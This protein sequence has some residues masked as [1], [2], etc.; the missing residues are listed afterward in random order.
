MP[1]SDACGCCGPDSR[2]RTIAGLLSTLLPR[3]QPVLEHEEVPL[4]A[5]RG[6]VLAVDLVATRPVPD[7]RRSA[8]DGYA[9]RPGDV[10]DGAGELMLPLRGRVAAGDS[11]LDLPD[12]PGLVRILTGAALPSA[13]DRVVMQEDCREQ[14]GMVHVRKIPAAGANVRLPGDDMEAGAVAVPAGTRLDPRHLAAAATL[15]LST[16][17]VCRRLRVAVL[18]TGSELV[19]PGQALRPGAIHNSNRF[20]IAGLLENMGFEVVDLPTVADDPE[21]VKAALRSAAGCDA[22]VTSGGVSVGD[23][24]HVRT[25]LVAVGGAIDHWRLAIKPGKPLA[26][27][28]LPGHDGRRTL[29]LGLPGNPNAVL[30]TLALVGLPLL[31]TLAGSPHAPPARLRVRTGGPIRHQPGREEYVS[32]ALRQADDGVPVA[33]RLGHGSSAQQSA[34]AAAD[35]LLIVPAELGSV[36]AGVLLDALPLAGLL[37]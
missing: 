17:P 28:H 2:D 35:A 24:D 4:R 30:V 32:V 25:A 19:E 5:A 20:L 34:M 21:Q 33:D 11:G 23:E 3:L 9:L 10:P 12:G 29:F 6:R 31:R 37:G 8:M 14:A 16:V 15:G 27:G 7:F 22:L 36:E 13:C 18:S 1:S 26:V